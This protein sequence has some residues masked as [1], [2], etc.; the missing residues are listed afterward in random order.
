L[1]GALARAASAAE[2]IFAVASGADLGC[3]ERTACDLMS[4]AGADVFVRV[5]AAV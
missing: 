4:G 3:A 5:L 2:P 1:S